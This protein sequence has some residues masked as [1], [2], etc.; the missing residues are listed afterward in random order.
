MITPNIGANEITT[1]KPPEFLLAKV[2]EVNSNINIADYLVSEKFDGVR[3]FWDGKNL[4]SRGKEIIEA[5]QWFLADF[6]K[7]IQLDGELWLGRNKGDF[8]KISALTRQK[9]NANNSKKINENSW[10][11]VK[12][13]IFE[14]PSCK[15]NFAQRYNTLLQLKQSNKIKSNYIEIIPQIKLQ[16][17]NE[18]LAKFDEIKKIGG[19]G[20][21]LHKATSAYHTG[22]S[23]DL[24]K[25]KV[26][27]E[28]I[29]EVIAYKNGKGKYAGKVGS[30]KV[31]WKNNE[32]NSF[33]EF[34]IGSGLS[35]FERENPPKIGELVEF[36]FS[37]FTKTG[38]PRFPIFIKVVEKN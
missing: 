11:N 19:E 7:N 24:L 3:A 37:E 22:R 17:Q 6:P 36:K 4:W 34:N 2:Y 9:N 10:K 21:M 16:N 26:W 12:F 31:R 15:G 32:L 25:Y 20:L 30:L 1:T 33:L 5:P 28:S 14:C 18:L 29:A 13:L 35:D 8:E 23:S 27:Q 38:K